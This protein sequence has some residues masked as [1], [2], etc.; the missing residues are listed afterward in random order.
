MHNKFEINRTMIKGSCQSG[1]N[2]VTHD[3]KSDLPLL[4]QNDTRSMVPCSVA[5]RSVAVCMYYVVRYL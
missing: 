4:I 2:V 3:S 5:R 1:R